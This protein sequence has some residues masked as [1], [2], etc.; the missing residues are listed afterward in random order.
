VDFLQ[1][2]NKET[3]AHNFETGFSFATKLDPQEKIPG[4]SIVIKTG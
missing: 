1:N 3:P 2:N 4:F